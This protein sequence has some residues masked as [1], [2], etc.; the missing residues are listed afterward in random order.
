MP[1]CR[2]RAARRRSLR[3]AASQKRPHTSCTAL[4]RVPNARCC[5]YGKSNGVAGC[6]ARALDRFAPRTLAAFV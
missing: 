5:R 6:T 2:I 4:A 3:N 1:S